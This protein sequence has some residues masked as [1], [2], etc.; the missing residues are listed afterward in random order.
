M[1]VTALLG[2]AGSDAQ[3]KSYA[4][5]NNGPLSAFA[6]RRPVA[7]SPN[8]EVPLT[9]CTERTA[10]M[11]SRIVRTVAGGLCLM[12]RCIPLVL[13]LETVTL[14][15]CCVTDVDS[16]ISLWLKKYLTT[17]HHTS[18]TCSMLPR[19]KGGVV[20][21]ELRVYGT[22]RLR[23]VDLSVVPLIPS[24]HT[25][26]VVYAVAEQAADIIKGVFGG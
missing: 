24:A 6:E 3:D 7:A 11:I 21:S 22:R 13:L 10:S 17:V 2:R 18:S 16:D 14:V 5:K 4:F 25:Q 19:D 12:A 15:M 23:V 20:D 1:D 26:S 9:P 8:T